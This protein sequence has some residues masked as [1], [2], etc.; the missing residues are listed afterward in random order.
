MDL[1]QQSD[2]SAMVASTAS[3]EA[4][5]L[6]C[7]HSCMHVS[8]HPLFIGWLPRASE[9]QAVLTELCILKSVCLI[10]ARLD[11]SFF[12]FSE[13]FFVCLFLFTRPFFPNDM[14]VSTF[15]F[16]FFLLFP[17]FAFMNLYN[18]EVCFWGLWWFSQRDFPYHEGFIM[19]KRKF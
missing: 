13:I 8:A 18:W 1:C 6:S 12:F 15:S 10:T 3:P 9:I 17:A 16:F 19:S 7:F 4:G 2:A 14:D 11:Y 5:A